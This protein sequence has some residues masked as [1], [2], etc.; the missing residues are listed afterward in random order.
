MDVYNI[1]NAKKD[2]N[3]THDDNDD[4]LFG[5]GPQRKCK[6]FRVKKTGKCAST[7]KC[8]KGRRSI[9]D[10]KCPCKSKKRYNNGKCVPSARK[11]K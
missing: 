11:K 6:I 5:D 8:K 9:K 1:D 2:Y 3:E 10:G 7:R 4:F